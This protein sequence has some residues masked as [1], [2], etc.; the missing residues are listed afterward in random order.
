MFYTGFQSYQAF[1]AFYSFLGPGPDHLCCSSDKTMSSKKKRCNRSLPPTEELF[2]TLI[3]LRVG[4]MEQDL[5]Y[6]FNVSQSTVSR[7]TIKWINFMY[8]V[9]PH[10]WETLGFNV[11]DLVKTECSGHGHR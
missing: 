11:N 10:L 5:L 7:T 2:L 3:C 8:S 1:E 6:R 9:L 4:L